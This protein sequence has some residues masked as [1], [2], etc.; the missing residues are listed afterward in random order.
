MV[1]EAANGRMDGWADGART[2]AS[3][4]DPPIRQSANPPILIIHSPIGT[5]HSVRFRF[6]QQV[7]EPRLCAIGLQQAEPWHARR[8]PEGGAALRRAACRFRRALR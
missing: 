1:R 4:N 3:T 8:D 2:I 5:P 7:D 6:L